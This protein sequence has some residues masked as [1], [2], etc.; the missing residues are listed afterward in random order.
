M[1]LKRLEVRNLRNLTSVSLFPSPALN[2]I[3]GENASGKTSLLESIHL[4]GLARSFRSSK[5]EHLIQHHQPSFTLFAEIQHHRDLH[6]LGLQR[7]N[8]NHLT[9]R[10][11][12]Q[13]VESRSK[14]AS[15]LPLQVI[16]PDSIHLLTGG[17][18]ERR[19]YLDWL[20]FHVEP[21]FHHF[22]NLYQRSLKQRNA[23][24]RQGKTSTLSFWD[25]GVI[26]N[27]EAIDSLR[28]GV[29][30]R[31]LPHIRHY[32]GILLP[33]C[34]FQLSYR[35]GWKSDLQLGDSLQRSVDSDL[36]LK[37]T[38]TGPHRADL[39]FK[40]GDEKVAEVF[41]RGQLKLLLCVLKLAQMALLRDEQNIIP[42]VLIDDLPAEL[43]SYHRKQLLTLLH[44]LSTQVF[45]TTT[46]RD[47]LE[48]SAWSDVKLFHVEHGV[49][50]EVV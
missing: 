22:W 37:Y 33:Q 9:I 28:K 35:Q 19:R 12:G 17:P 21:N 47:L 30:R 41:S 13:N 26:E 18:A 36:K 3:E 7:F 44:E 34:D 45:V 6:R 5:A 24:L 15:L 1:F 50:K 48:F 4:L 38:T 8:D 43:D 46:S 11:D 29:I 23:L 10:I 16:T 27:G 32:A 39:I 14:L 31:L 40:D 42:L 20:M 49:I 25:Q 2:I